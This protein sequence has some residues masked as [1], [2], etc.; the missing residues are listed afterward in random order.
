[1]QIVTRWKTS[2]TVRRAR[3]VVLGLSIS[4]LAG[5]VPLRAD[6]GGTKDFEARMAE[7]RK[8]TEGRVRYERLDP[9][10]SEDGKFLFYQREGEDGWWQVALADGAKSAIEKLPE[11]TLRSPKLRRNGDKRRLR[12]HGKPRSPDR[13]W[14]VAFRE[15]EVVL[16]DHEAEEETVLA[17]PEGEGERF[18]SNVSWSANSKHFVVW[19]RNVAEP[20]RVHFVESS[21]D[22]QVQPKQHSHRYPKPGDELSI[23]RPILFS[24]QNPEPM[25]LDESLTPNPFELRHWGWA[26]DQGAERFRF[27]YIERG[28]GKFR[29]IEMDAATRRQRI[30][31]NEE[32]DTFVYVFG[33]SFRHD[34]SDDLTLWLS[35]R[36][37]WNHLYLMD[38]KSGEV[39]RQLTKGEW[40]VRKVVRVDEDAGTALLQIGGYYPDQDPY[41]VHWARLDLDD[42]ALTLLTSSNGTHEIEFS[43]DGKSLVARWSRTDQPPVHELRRVADGSLVTVLERGETADLAGTGWQV[44]E[45]F[46][47]KG[48]DGRFDIWGVIIRPPNFDPEKQYAVV[49]QIY[50]GPHGAFVPK[51]WSRWHGTRSEMAEA[52][53]I[54]VQ[55]DG[56]GTAHR[57]KEFQHFAYKNL[58]DAGFPDRIAWLKAA[59]AKYPQ[60][61]LDR[62]GIYGGSA[63]GQSA[64]GALLFH[65]DFYDAAV[66]DC[67]CHDN[68]MDKIWWNE[69]WMDWPLGP[70]YADNSNVTHADKLRGKLFLTV[71]ELDRNVD[72]ASTLQVVN[73][74]I[75]ADKDFE[76]CV[77]PGAGHGVGERPYLRRR[78]IEFFQR[79]LGGPN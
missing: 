8:R 18:D 57:G 32:S 51:R 67:G 36:D 31:I 47:A 16:R 43:P 5:A 6:H 21:P 62:V 17:S 35:E 9:R 12:S 24:V 46:V 13:R 72:P 76:L 49:E 65:G 56:R 45:P 1:M 70:H 26:D 54:V 48:R 15:G 42:G 60:L 71:G 75:E 55:I 58:K 39:E 37:G 29:V 27:E 20:R 22:D 4:G 53:F 7:A 59:A 40:V 28:F 66:A 69:Q 74:L 61:D 78:R 79:H 23:A 33:Q 68:R 63:G 30:V 3:C 38:G 2:Q 34:L 73:A 25:P 52:G 41:F 10:W 14:E 50:A 77:V 44:P 64:L 11:D 19:K